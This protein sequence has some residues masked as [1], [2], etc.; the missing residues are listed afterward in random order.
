MSGRYGGSRG[1]AEHLAAIHGTEDD[2]VNCPFFFKIGACRHGET[3]Q[4]K[5][6]RPPF[7]QTVLVKQMWFNP[8]ISVINAGGDPRTLDDANVQKDFDLFYEELFEEARK[9]GTVE[10][11]QVLE[12]LGDHMIGS[13]YIRFVDE[14]MAAAAL[15]GLNGRF[16]GGRVLKC[17]FSAVTDF[18][19]SR[20]RQYDEDYCSR[21]SYCNFMHVREPSRALRNYLEQTYGY[22]GGRTRGRGDMQT[23]G[24]RGGGGGR[25]GREGRRDD[26]RDRSRD[27]GRRRDDSRDRSR[28]RDR[29][30]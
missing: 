3:C 1:G 12:N 5:H 18:R 21:E 24:G 26:S 13:V 27:R 28:S 6:H 10:D 19:E 25:G 14:D 2:R 17:E 20:C 7:S 9:F 22:R 23:L 4:R 11:I 29:R 8:M 15:T 16:Y 30:R